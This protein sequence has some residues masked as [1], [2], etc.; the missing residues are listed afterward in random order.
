MPEIGPMSYAE[1]GPMS[2]PRW[3]RWGRYWANIVW[4][5]GMFAYLVNNDPVALYALI[6]VFT[7]KRFWVIN[8]YLKM[9]FTFD[10]HDIVIISVILQ[11]YNY[12]IKNYLC[13]SKQNYNSGSTVMSGMPTH[14]GEDLTYDS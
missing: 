3:P 4:L 7:R 13:D 9:L 10:V 2:V 11:S 14:L 1:I 8:F 5:S 12:I 6:T